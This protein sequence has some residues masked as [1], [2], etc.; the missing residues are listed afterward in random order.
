MKVKIDKIRCILSHVYN[1]DRQ[2]CYSREY[3]WNTPRYAR[4]FGMI[5][6]YLE[7]YSTR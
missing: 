4:S 7:I 2:L 6:M 1:I 3:F 5:E